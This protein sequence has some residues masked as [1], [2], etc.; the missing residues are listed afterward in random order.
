M[1]GIAVY[2][3]EAITPPT[4]A[5]LMICITVSVFIVKL[6]LLYLSNE[7]CCIRKIQRTLW[8]NKFG[9][10]DERFSFWRT[11]IHLSLGTSCTAWP[12]LSF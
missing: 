5:A 3:F 10:N 7:C 11:Y 6:D 9:R 2:C 1:L 12:L 8:T 4:R